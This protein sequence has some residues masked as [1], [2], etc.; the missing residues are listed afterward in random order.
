MDTAAN[1]KVKSCKVSQH[2]R[3]LRENLFL[4]AVI[5]LMFSFSNLEQRLLELSVDSLEIIYESDFGVLCVVIVQNK[6]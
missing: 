3:L 2:C 4:D 1:I 6:H 5:I